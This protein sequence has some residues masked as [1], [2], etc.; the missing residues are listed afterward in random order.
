[1]RIRQPK[2]PS[3]VQYP[4]GT[5][6]LHGP[7]SEQS[8]LI[9]AAVTYHQDAEPILEQWRTHDLTDRLRASQEIRALFRMHRVRTVTT[10]DRNIGCA[11]A[12]GVDYPRGHDCPY[13]HYWQG[14]Q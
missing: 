9:T 5:V 4:V 12:A 2:S 7:N 6:A 10:W 3:F 11:H 8:T 13:C 1:M 14:R